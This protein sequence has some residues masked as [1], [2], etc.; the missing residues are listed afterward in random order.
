ML[1]MGVD[2]GGTSTRAVLATAEGECIGYGR[3]G[4]GNPTSSGIPTALAGVRG[5]I[6]GALDGTGATLADVA[7]I[8]IA[9]AGHD[10]RGGASDWILDPLAQDGF[11]GT[12]TFESDLLAMYSS[13]AVAPVGYGVV[14]GTGAS[15][16]RVEGGRIVAT[17]DGLGWLLG[18]RGSGFWIG[19]G[20]AAAA[21]DELE[22]I[23]PSTVLTSLVLRATGAVGEGRSAEGRPAALEQL[24]RALYTRRPVQLA[25]FA[26]LVF[27][28]ADA[29]DPVAVRILTDAG[30]QLVRTLELVS[31]RPGP[32]VAGGSIV[33]RDG[34][35]QRLLRDHLAN[36]FGD[37]PFVLVDSGAA[38]ATMLALRH[39]GVAVDEGTL[40]RVR[41][42]I[43]V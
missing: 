43:P 40:A 24:V 26:P 9:M 7:G 18:D 38:G 35:P 37:Q 3:G 31:A 5:A 16:V 30:E 2:A 4:S 10:A 33:S 21:V 20:A 22:G 32:V 36:A 1:V 28:A 39:A 13:G 27:D 42:G 15:A 29:Q 25:E 41:T 23:G 6:S 17:A 12:L 11:A 19:R 14:C 34:V 8:V